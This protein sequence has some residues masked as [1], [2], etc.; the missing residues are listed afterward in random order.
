MG[1]KESSCVKAPGWLWAFTSW[2]V[3]R[4]PRGLPRVPSLAHTTGGWRWGVGDDGQDLL[5]AKRWGQLPVA[6]RLT[7]RIQT[8]EKRVLI[9]SD[10][11]LVPEQSSPV[12]VLSDVIL[13]CLIAKI[14]PL[15]LEGEK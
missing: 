10:A 8:P 6:D 7:V 15:P 4:I 1:G 2:G 3:G 13:P 5:R 9:S 14:S 11:G 12:R